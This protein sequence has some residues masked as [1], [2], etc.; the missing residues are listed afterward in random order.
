MGHG[1]TGSRHAGAGL[2]H[3]DVRG[4][5]TGRAVGCVVRRVRVASRAHGHRVRVL[6]GRVNGHLVGDHRGARRRH[7]RERPDDR[8]GVVGV[9]RDAVRCQRRAAVHVVHAGREHV[10]HRRRAGRRRPDVGH[11]DL[12]LGLLADLDR[13]G[14]GL[15]RVE[16]GCERHLDL[17]RGRVVV[18]DLFVAGRRDRDAVG[19][20][21][22]VERSL[23]SDLDVIGQR[24]LVGRLTGRQRADVEDVG[25]SV[26]P[27]AGRIGNAIAVELCAAGHVGETVLEDVLDL[28]VE[29]DTGA[30]VAERDRVRDRVARAGLR[31]TTVLGDR[32]VGDAAD[33]DGHV[34]LGRLAELGNQDPEVLA[35]ALGLGLDE[36]LDLDGRAELDVGHEPFERGAVDRG[37][38]RCAVDRR[39]VLVGQARGQHVLDREV[40]RRALGPRGGGDQRDRGRLADREVLGHDDVEAV[41]LLVDVGRDDLVDRERHVLVANAD[42]GAVDDGVTDVHV[43]GGTTP[44]RCAA[45]VGA[46]LVWEGEQGAV[47]QGQLAA[48]GQREVV[49]RVEALGDPA[50]DGAE[51][52]AVDVGG[53]QARVLVGH[54]VDDRNRRAPGCTDGGGGAVALTD[55]ERVLGRVGLVGDLAPDDGVLDRAAEV[56]EHPGRA[57]GVVEGGLDL[58]DERSG[59]G[60][61]KH[62]HGRLVALGEPDRV[63]A[64]VRDRH[65]VEGLDGPVHRVAPALLAATTVGRLG[66]EAGSRCDQHGK[67]DKQVDGAATVLKQGHD[68][69]PPVLRRGAPGPQPSGLLSL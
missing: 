61:G 44:V 18:G 58:V 36:E 55:Q 3:E 47:G 19:Q 9:W 43:A 49:P 69:F 48:R 26:R 14:A 52:G 7:A 63:A 68:G 24:V 29:G 12:V 65:G 13:A 10:R 8:R 60:V 11:G 1:R 41:D 17:A 6:A 27:A 35:L 20:V 23:V 34:V 54:R 31:V 30:D 62:A 64:R 21:L 42:V 2:R 33:V 57:V 37:L 53:C 15:G 56:L 51:L 50:T 45:R 22:V 25:V 66:G 67:A 32:Q 59:S 16:V 38:L 4:Q 28:D 39:A 5:R 40:H 46:V